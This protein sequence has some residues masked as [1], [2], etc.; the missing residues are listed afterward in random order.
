MMANVADELT[1]VFSLADYWAA[2][3][4]YKL[5]YKEMNYV[6]AVL[7]D[8]G[9]GK[10]TTAIAE[11]V[12]LD[13]TFDINRIV[14][15]GHEYTQQLKTIKPGQQ[16]V[17]DETGV[18]LNSREAMTKMNKDMSYVLQTMRFKQNG[19]FMTCPDSSFLDKAARLMIKNVFEAQRILR[20]YKLCLVKPYIYD[21]RALSD[22][23]YHHF[24]VIT[25]GQKRITINQFAVQK[26][27]NELIK[28]Y[29]EKKL[30][31]FEEHVLG[32]FDADYNV[33]EIKAETRQKM[34]EEQKVLI[35]A[36]V[37]VVLE[38]PRVY[39]HLKSSGWQFSKSRIKNA[40]N[41]DEKL[42]EDIKAQAEMKLTSRQNVVTEEKQGEL[43]GKQVD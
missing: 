15:S 20:T 24:P 14:F 11:A 43:V 8:S 1:T 35:A 17:W 10:S 7:G 29:K 25:I 37:R 39:G 6:Q 4:K 23:I 12:K 22:D 42:A 30:E 33:S 5:L 32:Q 9:T 40:F 28:A 18:G 13:P 26:P 34:L 16:I 27:N 3:I 21:R 41:V 19:L 36:K 31:F 2:D 38:Q